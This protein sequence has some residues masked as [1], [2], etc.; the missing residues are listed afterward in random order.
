[1]NNCPRCN[2]PEVV[3]TSGGRLSYTGVYDSNKACG[4]C[5]LPPQPPKLPTAL[6]PM[7]TPSELALARRLLVT[8]A[9]EAD[10]RLSDHTGRG[11][12]NVI[13][14]LDILPVLLDIAEIV[15]RLEQATEVHRLADSNDARGLASAY[16]RILDQRNALQVA[17]YRLERQQNEGAA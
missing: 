17:L 5:G 12:Y 7:P 11:L 4:H 1:M 15:V 13:K 8:R 2:Y 16:A 10:T 6:P 3:F 9:T 14:V